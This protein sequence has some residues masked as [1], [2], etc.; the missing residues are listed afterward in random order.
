MSELAQEA[1]VFR[2]LYLCG[3]VENPELVTWADAKI[4]AGSIEDEILAIST[5]T[6]SNAAYLSKLKALSAGANKIEALRAVCAKLAEYPTA[7]NASAT[8]RQCA[9]ETGEKM[10]ADL[11]FLTAPDDGKFANHLKQV[12]RS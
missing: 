4:E 3:L 6:M 9:A 2:I 8:V 10:P 5:E 1:E 7:A 11:A 12:Q